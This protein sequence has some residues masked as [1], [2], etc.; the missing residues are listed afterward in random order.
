MAI[1]L[2]VQALVLGDGGL[3]AFGA[4]VINMALLPAG[5]V[6]L[7]RRLQV[8]EGRWS[9]ATCGLVAAITVPLAALLIVGQTAL[10]RSGAELAGWSECA[11]RMVGTHLAI[12]AIEAGLTVVLVAGLAW[13]RQANSA[14]SW[15]PAIFCTTAAIALAAIAAPWSS[16]LPDGYEAAASGAGL[17]SLLVEG[18][19]AASQMQAAVVG[20]MQQA[21]LGEYPALI[22]ATL[23]T[24]MLVLVAGWAITR[25]RVSLA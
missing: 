7:C 11:A 17:E 20:A 13:L 1:V 15:R 5:A 25:R 16:A 14:P 19:N 22:A 2:A 21:A 4:N 18:A 24:A 10:F 6:A 8:A 9:L 3:A 12:G 23:L